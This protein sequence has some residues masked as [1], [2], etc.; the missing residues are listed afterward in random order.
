MP[1]HSIISPDTIQE[2]STTKRRSL[3]PTWVK[4]TRQCG[5]VTHIRTPCSDPFCTD[6]QKLRSERALLKWGAAIEALNSPK[7]V[8]LSLK[9][10]KDINRVLT[11]LYRAFRRLM[12]TSLGPR[13]WPKFKKLSEAFLIEH[14]SKTKMDVKVLERKLG[15]LR[16]SLRRLEVSLTA[17][18]TRKAPRFRDFIDAGLRSLEVTY[19]YT[20]GYHPHFHFVAQMQFIPWELLCVLWEHA[21]RGHG[22]ITDIRAVRDEAGAKAEIFKYTVKGMGIDD[23]VREAVREALRGKKKIW[24]I[25]NFE[26][27][28]PTVKRCPHCEKIMRTGCLHDSVEFGYT[29]WST[30]EDRIDDVGGLLYQV[31]YH[32][33]D[34][35]DVLQKIDGQWSSVYLIPSVICAPGGIEIDV[36]SDTGAVEM[37]QMSMND[38][39]N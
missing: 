38:R 14:A 26:P 35:D 16:Q 4:V 19:S 21:S 7:F 20:H 15:R 17:V 23:S 31:K 24:V 13:N 30:P 25:G 5:G 18:S 39:L 34:G 28:E 3:C 6:C 2:G 11:D 32:Q 9:S 10:S 27:N 22:K 8:T 29:K 1:D 37:S 12:H 36:T 33:T